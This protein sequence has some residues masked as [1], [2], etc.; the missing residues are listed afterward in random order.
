TRD[1]V[2]DEPSGWADGRWLA[3]QPSWTAKVGSGASSPLVAG[4]HVYTLG[5]IEGH[6]VV[7]GLGIRDGKEVWI[8]KY[9]GP[10]N[11]RVPAGDESLYSGPSSTPEYDPETKLLYTLGSD[12]DL[13]CWDTAAAGHEV[14]GL[15]LYDGYR[16]K[17]RPRL[18][19]AP[20]RDYGYTS[21]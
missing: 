2:I 15:N 3:E 13:R 20:Q 18:T 6:D 16:V 14:W 8:A 19:R 1:G 4:D 12:G 11:G 9:R 7:W 21:S 10:E 17:Q 5:R